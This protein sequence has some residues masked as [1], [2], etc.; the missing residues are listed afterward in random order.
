MTKIN[1]NNK[2]LGID[3]RKI[4]PLIYKEIIRRK[5]FKDERKNKRI[6]EEKL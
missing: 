6:Y 4:E 3:V 1:E 5:L 2:K